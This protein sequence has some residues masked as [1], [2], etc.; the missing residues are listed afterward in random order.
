MIP[1]TL[2]I[3]ALI[4]AWLNSQGEKRGFY[5]WCLSNVGFS[6]YNAWIGEYA[7]CALFFAYLLITVNGMRK[8]K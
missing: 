1:W 2:T 7:M 6:V 8:W 3:I 4:G 5:Y